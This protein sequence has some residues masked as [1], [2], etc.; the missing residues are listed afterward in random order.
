MK[1]L[2]AV[3]G[4]IA[5]GLTIVFGLGSASAAEKCVNVSSYEWIGEQQTMDP[6][7]IT[8]TDDLAHVSAV[9][10]GLVDLDNNYEAVPA[11]AEILGV[12]CHR[13]RVDIPSS[14]RRKIS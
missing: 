3:T 7:A 5:A 13:H 10:E 8:S 4:G 2:T 9:F 12:E 11:L 14:Q 1:N 6:V